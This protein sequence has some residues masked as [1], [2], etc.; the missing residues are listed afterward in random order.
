MSGSDHDGGFFGSVPTSMMQ[1]NN[2]S[3]MY[4]FNPVFGPTIDFFNNQPPNMWPNQNHNYPVPS[5]QYS[6]DG[7]DISSPEKEFNKIDSQN[8][9]I[10]VGRN[11]NS[12]KRGSYKCSRCGAAKKGHH[13]NNEPQSQATEVETLKGR[14]YHLEEEKKD[15]EKKMHDQQNTINTLTVENA[16][17]HARLQD[18]EKVWTMLERT[19]GIPRQ[20]IQQQI[21]P[22]PSAPVTSTRATSATSVPEL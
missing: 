16:Q 22:F 14:V 4:P 10:K 20:T 9:R 21:Y 7:G 18:F 15:H 5:P 17:L 12:Q 13:C 1:V 2:V 11:S 6:P 8:K 3:T 19:F